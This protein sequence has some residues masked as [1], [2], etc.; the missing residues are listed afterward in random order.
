MTTALSDAGVL[1]ADGNTQP[2]VSV[3]VRQTVLN[4]PVDANGQSAFGGATGATTVTTAG[5]LFMTAANGMSNRSGSKVNPSWSGLSANGT[6]Y[7]YADVNVDGTITEGANALLP[8]YQWGGTPAI[9]TGQL[10]FNIQQMQGFLGNGTTALA[11]YRVYV[12]EV[13]VAAGV[14]SAI[15]WYAIMG[16]YNSGWFAVAIATTYNKSTNIGTSID[17]RK[18]S[19]LY[20]Q[21]SSYVAR[22]LTYCFFDG[23][24]S[25]GSAV[26][27]V[28][29][30]T[31]RVRT[32]NGGLG[33]NTGD[34]SGPIGS[35]DGTTFA[36]GQY[37]ITD[38]RGW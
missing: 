14:V 12:G 29:R 23:T 1:F 2:Y 24:N 5:T 25:Y 37:L 33:A 28:D 34:L 4:G 3:P 30:N 31:L 32:G 19:L 26:G 21:S 7:L 13:T 11:A 15:V 6:M 16:R 8:I 17:T 22:L 38:D 27:Y 10:T 35:N 9:T 36:S 20:R 18:I